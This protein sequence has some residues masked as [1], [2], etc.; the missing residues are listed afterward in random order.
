MSGYRFPWIARFS[1][2]ALTSIAVA[3]VAIAAVG[4]ELTDE[5]F[6]AVFA[7]FAAFAVVG[8]I[9]NFGGSSGDLRYSEAEVSR[10]ARFGCVMAAFFLGLATVA[11][12]DHF[13]RGIAVWVCLAAPTFGF[14]FKT[15][16]LVRTLGTLD[17][18]LNSA[19]TVICWLGGRRVHLVLLFFGWRVLALT[20]KNL[21]VIPVSLR[22][23]PVTTTIPV[24]SITRFQYTEVSKLSPVLS[25]D[26]GG[27][28]SIR[29]TPLPVGAQETMRETLQRAGAPIE[30]P[31][32]KD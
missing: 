18:R 22:R 29:V 23:L 27:E 20:E 12:A 28:Q 1:A 10:L 26:D 32:S 5:V 31:V 7:A 24:K 30:V 13:A 25:V 17:E 9:L 4:A 8:A 19:E 3:I 21:Y 16:Q 2:I 11:S 15:T 6:P 14:A